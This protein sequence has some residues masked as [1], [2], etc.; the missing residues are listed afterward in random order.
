LS[1][2]WRRPAACASPQA[3]DEIGQGAVVDAPAVLGSGYRK[4]D[5][6]VGLSDPRRAEEDDVLLALQ[7]S[8]FGE[9]VD[10][11]A[12]YRRLEREIEALESLDATCHEGGIGCERTLLYDHSRQWGR[13]PGSRR[14]RQQDGPVRNGCG[15]KSRPI[16]Q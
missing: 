15:V 5:R 4:T 7:E 11:F 6:Q 3:E 8:G 13:R 14:G 2:C 12:A 16:V 1:R 9:A 10:L